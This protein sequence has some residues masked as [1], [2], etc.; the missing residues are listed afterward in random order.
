[1]LFPIQIIAAMTNNINIVLTSLNFSDANTGFAVGYDYNHNGKIYST[2]NGGTNW[3]VQSISPEHDLKSVKY[4]DAHTVCIVGSNGG[5]LKT[6][7]GTTS[8]GNNGPLCAGDTL[9]LSASA[10]TGVT[11]IWSGPDGFTSTLQNPTV[12]NNA[13]ST[14]SGIYSVT[15]TINS[16]TSLNETTTVTVT[17]MPSPPTAGSNGPLCAGDTLSLSAAAI[18]GATYS[19]TGPDGFTSTQQNPTVSNHASTAMSG[20]YNVS[21]TLNTCTSSDGTTTVTV[22]AMPSPPT[23][24][25]NGPVALATTLTLSASTI[26]GATYS[27]TGPN[28]FTSSVQNPV[29]S[30]NT[31]SA[32]AGNYDVYA[33]VNACT[34]VAGSTLVLVDSTVGHSEIRKETTLTIFPNPASEKISIDYTGMQSVKML[35]YNLMGDCVFQSDLTGSANI[36]DFSFLTSGV[37]MIRLTGAN[38]TMQ[39]K[40]I[41][42]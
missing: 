21:A 3:N 29:V 16:C 34:S 11:Y 20:S 2:V 4:A 5:I 32:M 7:I 6:I 42:N 13:L 18:T 23:A 33:T 36:I 30:T 31:T 26:F 17:A 39:R 37:Y 25:N 38:G 40:F 15:A 27:W 41:K 10:I 8:A 12:S 22:N 24:E 28:N 19:W 1:M 35:V 14:M 9:S